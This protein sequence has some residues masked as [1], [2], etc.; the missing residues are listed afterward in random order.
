MKW[1]VERCGRIVFFA[2]SVIPD[3]YKSKY[4]FEQFGRQLT[5]DLD[6]SAFLIA[7]YLEDE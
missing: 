1:E 7:K 6:I 4:G 2:T 3:V 5:L